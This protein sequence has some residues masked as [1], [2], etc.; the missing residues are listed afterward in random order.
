MRA[1]RTLGQLA[2]LVGGTLLSG[3]PDQTVEEL[4]GL[5]DAEPGDLS[6]YDG[7]PKFKK[8]ALA[9]R[10]GALL[11][12]ESFAPF[13]GAQIQVTMPYLAFTTLVDELYPEPERPAGVDA[14][15]VVSPAA[16]VDPTAWVGPNATVGPD[17]RI[18]AR[19]VVHANVS[20]RGDVVIGEDCVLHP[21]VTIYP[22]SRIG[23]RVILH[24]G[25]VI[26]SDGFGYRRDETGLRKIRHVGYVEVQDDVEMGANCAID[27]GTFGRT[28]VGKGSKLDNMVHLGHNVRIG[29][30]VML[31]AQVVAAGGSRVGNDAVIGGQTAISDH[32]V[33]GDA[34]MIIGQSAVPKR[35]KAGTIVGGTPVMSHRDWL[36][37]SKAL[38]YLPKLLSRVRA[39]EKKLGLSAKETS[40]GADDE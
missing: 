30:R 8:A 5:E 11:V 38:P 35:V 33:V 9:T 23:N 17:V 27:R 6:F 10:A 34:A 29:E 40:G 26:G 3:S 31:I 22:R 32:A 16:T 19:S 36:L 21:N 4:A 28:V 15:A 2:S 13:K 1:P 14:S 24:A 25:T 12:R 39:I 7:N 20:I 18:G 37:T